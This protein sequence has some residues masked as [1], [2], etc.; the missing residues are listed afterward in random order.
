MS[1]IA[2]YICNNSTGKIH[3][4]MLKTLYLVREALELEKKV[5]CPLANVVIGGIISSTLLMLV[6]LPILS[7]WINEKKA[8]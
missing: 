1:N 4:I 5:K 7:R 2:F 8:S 6:L 3:V